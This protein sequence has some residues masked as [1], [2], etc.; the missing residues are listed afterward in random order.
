MNP[1]HRNLNEENASNEAGSYRIGD[2][3]PAKPKKNGP[4]MAS[5]LEELEES[6]AKLKTINAELLEALKKAQ[7]FMQ[8]V[9]NDTRNCFVGDNADEYETQIVP[10]LQAAITKATN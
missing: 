4:I 7:S 10:M 1:L 9:H 6:N 3:V 8:Y 5:M 2:N